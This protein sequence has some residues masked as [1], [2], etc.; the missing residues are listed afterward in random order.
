MA[1]FHSTLSN[2]CFHP[3]RN[4]FLLHGEHGLLAAFASLALLRAFAFLGRYSV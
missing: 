4:V 3:V 2:I 1:D